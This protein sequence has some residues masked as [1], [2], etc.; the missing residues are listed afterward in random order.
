M[1]FKFENLTYKNTNYIIRFL[2]PNQSSGRVSVIFAE[3]SGEINFQM[4]G[5]RSSGRGER[6]GSW[7]KP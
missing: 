2:T 7:A 6:F 1:N 4:F 5:V 3:F